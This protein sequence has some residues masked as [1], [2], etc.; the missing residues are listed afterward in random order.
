MKHLTAAALS[1]SMA[2]ATAAHGQESAS[3]S[4]IEA[5]RA[6]SPALK[7]YTTDNLY[8]DLWQSPNLSARDRS[9][10]TVASLIARNQAADMRAEFSR[11]LENG[12]TPAELS[13]IIT[14]LAFYAGWGNAMSAVEVAQDLCAL[15]EWRALCAE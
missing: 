12:V 4:A 3:D 1:L 10:V 13:E 11:A 9:I 2:A 7:A 5:I 8:G 15:G 14:H 6:V